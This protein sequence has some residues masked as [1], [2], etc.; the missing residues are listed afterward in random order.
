MDNNGLLAQ[1][2][3]SKLHQ[4]EF[5][6]NTRSRDSNQMQVMLSPQLKQGNQSYDSP[7]I[8]QLKAMKAQ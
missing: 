7:D 3:E 1:I 8:R 6:S 5:V 4:V 2:A